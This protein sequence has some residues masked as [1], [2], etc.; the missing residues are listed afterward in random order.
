ML[1]GTILVQR[2]SLASN[3]FV[4][5]KTLALQEL[6]RRSPNPLFCIVP[7]QASRFC[8]MLFRHSAGVRSHHGSVM[9]AG[10]GIASQQAKQARQSCNAVR[11]LAFVRTKALLAD[12]TWLNRFI[13]SSLEFF[14]ESSG[15]PGATAPNPARLLSTSMRL[16]LP[17][18]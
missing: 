10:I 8:K 7:M 4:Y 12:A 14:P 17:S 9:F 6:V 2:N 3:V 13:S 5:T 1:R 15:L 16:R 18:G 11:I